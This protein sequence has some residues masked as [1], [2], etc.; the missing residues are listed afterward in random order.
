M[1]GNTGDLKKLGK[2]GCSGD[3]GLRLDPD[4]DPQRFLHWSCS[5]AV[6]KENEDLD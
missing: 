4:P 2:C 6:K 3:I 1:N 5:P